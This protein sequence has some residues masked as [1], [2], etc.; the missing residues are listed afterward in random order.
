MGKSKHIVKLACI[1]E[2]D[3]RLCSIT[4]GAVSAAALAAVRVNVNPAAVFD[5]VFK[6]CGIIVAENTKRVYCNIRSFFKGVLLV[7][8]A[9][10]RRVNIISEERRGRASRA[11]SHNNYIEHQGFRL[12]S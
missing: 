2:Q 9:D 12:Q 7:D 1:V 8:G 3:I 6:C 5:S 4:A 10:E 11:S